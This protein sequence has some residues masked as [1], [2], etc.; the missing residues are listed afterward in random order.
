MVNRVPAGLVVC[1]GD[2]YVPMTACAAC[3]RF[4]LHVDA[5]RML[6]KYGPHIDVSA[7]DYYAVDLEVASRA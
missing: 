1:A 3:C 5:I 6:D 4:E 7:A 2:M